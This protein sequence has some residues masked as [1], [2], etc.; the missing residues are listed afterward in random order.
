MWCEVGFATDA[1]N[2]SIL[3]TDISDFVEWQDGVRISRRRAHELDLVTPGTLTARLLNADG[4]FTA[5]N[6]A[7]PYY[8]YVLIN[9]P[10]RIRVRYPASVNLIYDG[11]AT[12]AEPQGFAVSQGTKAVDF[13]VFPAGQTR[14]IRWDAGTLASTGQTLRIGPSALTSPTDEATPILEGLPYAFSAQARTTVSVSAQLRIRWYGIDSA[15]ISETSGTA[16]ALTTSFQ[17][18]SVAGTAPA[19]AMWARLVLANTTTTGSATS[20]YAGAFQFEQAATASAWVLPGDEDFRYHGFVDKWPSVWHRGVL[21]YSSLVATDLQ[22]LLN[23]QRLADL[24]WISDDQ[25]SGLRVDGLLAAA[26]AVRDFNTLTDI[27]QSALGLS[28][29]E[30]TQSI[31]AN[32]RAAERSEGGIFFI[33]RTGTAHFRDRAFRQAPTESGAAVIELTGDQVGQDLSFLIDSDLLVNQITVSTDSGTEV[34]ASDLDSQAAYGQ[35]DGTLDTLLQTTTEATDRAQ[36]LLNQY[37]EPKPRAG[38]ISVEANA[39][40]DLWP[41]ML[42][43]EIGRRIQVTDL[44]DGTPTDTLDL[45]IE[46][47]QDVI[48]DQT[49]TFTFDTSPAAATAAFILDDATY[50]LLDNNYLG[51]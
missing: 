15:L 17:A 28:G 6:T 49:W 40:P 22:K 42:A 39:Q 41:D 11:W 36:Y 25:L 21:G 50:G 23:R 14:S 4:R 32:I 1:V 29:N 27:G 37:A 45:W 16:V 33:A 44:P 19:G 5:G 20:I 18:L 48:T 24:G 35:Y 7:S 46:G 9:R 38:R 43:S 26:Q 10:V 3:W 31:L 12:S 13:A 8:P 30:F 2:D 51:W 47:V 34:T